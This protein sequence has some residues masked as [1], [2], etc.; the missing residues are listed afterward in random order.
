MCWLCAHMRTFYTY[1]FSFKLSRPPVLPLLCKALYLQGHPRPTLKLL[2][3]NYSRHLCQG[4]VCI[5]WKSMYLESLGFEGFW[6]TKEMSVIKL[7]MRSYRRGMWFYKQNLCKQLTVS[8]YAFISTYSEAPEC[9]CSNGLAKIMCV[10]TQV[11]RLLSVKSS[12]CI[13][14]SWLANE[15][16]KGFLYYL[17]GNGV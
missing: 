15:L 16:I 3:S 13:C 2:N 17:R 10:I 6:R 4:D 14:V 11:M 7:T 12:L 9:V 1:G 8:L 5:L